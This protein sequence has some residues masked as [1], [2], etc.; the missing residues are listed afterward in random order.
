MLTC[1]LEP[2]ASA[3]FFC[4]ETVLCYNKDTA[5]AP[6]PIITNV[7]LVAVIK[8][9]CFLPLLLVNCNTCSVANQE[10]LSMLFRLVDVRLAQFVSLRAACACVAQGC[11]P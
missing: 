9:S 7:L 8:L 6:V 10:L 1:K 5:W 11:E 2:S 4:C 3:D